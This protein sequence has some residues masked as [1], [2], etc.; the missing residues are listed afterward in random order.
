[1]KKVFLSLFFI[2]QFL[3]IEAVE[4]GVDLFFKE[5]HFKK[6]S[7]KNI[8]LIINHTAR[9]GNLK[10]SLERFLKYSDRFYVKA[11]FAPEHGINGNIYAGKEVKNN[12]FKNI[13]IYSL[14]G[15]TRRPSSEMLK[16]ID[17]LIYDIQDLGSRSYTYVNTLFYVMEEAAKRNIEVIVL[18]R[19]NPINGITV[20][21]PMLEKEYRSFV[22]YVNV[23]YC[24]GMTVGELAR[25]F[26][27]EYGVKCRL[28]VIPMRGWKRGMSFSDTGL[29]WIPTSPNI[30][31]P[32]TPF[33]YPSTGILGELKILNIG[34]GYTMPFKVIGAPWIDAKVFAK[35]LNSQG[36][37][38]VFFMPFYF[39]PFYGLYEGQNCQGVKIVI[40][41]RKEYRPVT[42]QYLILGILKSLYPK[43]FLE[44]LEM[45]RAAKSMFFKVNGTRKV[46]DILKNEKFPAWKLIEFQKKERG[47]FLK[48][49]KKYL[50][51]K[52]G[53]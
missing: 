5:G 39:K 16:G 46:F 35:T 45:S 37:K 32:D 13:P 49:R 4:L 53:D 19:P 41:N 20:D 1:M 22:G 11:I 23:A 24:H 12:K 18:D 33:Y 2:F 7:K 42:V 14:H 27:C 10:S 15:K 38:G 44:K 26:N 31:E 9:D 47:E 30:P 51:P 21:G 28:R 6:I 3:F 25:F 43:V 48:K 34:I 8:G 52:Y 36:L 40:T 50:I 17:V 29:F